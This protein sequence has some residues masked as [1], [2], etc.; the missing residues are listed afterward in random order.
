MGMILHILRKLLVAELKDIR[1]DIYAEVNNMGYTFE[2]HLKRGI[3]E[4]FSTAAM[5]ILY[6]AIALSFSVG[7]VIIGL[8]GASKILEAYVDIPGAGFF[9]VGV[10]SLIFSFSIATK[11]T[12]SLKQE[13]RVEFEEK[14]KRGK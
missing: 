1:E 6:V 11:V 3:L 5:P 12:Q 9:I 4:A 2:F 10:I 14:S 7:A 13:M 8:Y